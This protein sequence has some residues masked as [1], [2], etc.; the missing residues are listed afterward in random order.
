GGARRLRGRGPFASD[1]LGGR[2]LYQQLNQAADVLDHVVRARKGVDV[3][4]VGRF[5]VLDRD[6]RGQSRDISSRAV[7]LDADVVDTVG[8][9]DVHAV[10]RAVG[11]A[12]I[13]V[14]L[15]HVRPGQ[16]LDQ[17][18]VGSGESVEVNGLDVIRV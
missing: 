17:N 15:G 9:V 18:G 7:P 5:R 3:E 14:G 2:S 4:V 1:F 13:Q 8:A 6:R 16:V 12:E 11:A 10:E